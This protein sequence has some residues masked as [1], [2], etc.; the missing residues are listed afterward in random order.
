MKTCANAIFQKTMES[1]P[2]IGAPIYECRV[3]V[4][5]LL[6]GSA[7]P[8]NDDELQITKALTSAME[9]ALLS[10]PSVLEPFYRFE[11]VVPNDC[12]VDSV[13]AKI[14]GQRGV[15]F[16]FEDDEAGR[17]CSQGMAPVENSLAIREQVADG[18]PGH[19]ELSFSAPF[20]QP[21]SGGAMEEGSE[22][23]ELVIRLRKERGMSRL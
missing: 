13:S 20:Y 10:S 12:D 8:S 3:E 22:F 5:P 21:I 11:L 16:G 23:H 18:I 6:R 14:E 19:F 2:I 9:E 17:K 4:W 15:V 1:R 7:S